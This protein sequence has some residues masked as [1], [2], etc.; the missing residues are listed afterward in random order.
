M[1]LVTHL[2]KPVNLSAKISDHEVSLKYAWFY[3]APIMPP[4]LPDQLYAHPYLEMPVA[5][6][7][8]IP[9]Y[10]ST[11]LTNDEIPSI[12]SLLPTFHSLMASQ[13]L[14]QINEQ[15]NVF[16][17]NQGNADSN[18]AKKIR[19]EEKWTHVEEV[20]LQS[21]EGVT[22]RRKRKKYFVLPFR[23]DL[24]EKRHSLFSRQPLKRL[25]L[26]APPLKWTGDADVSIYSVISSV[27]EPGQEM[28][29]STNWDR[30]L[31]NSCPFS[32]SPRVRKLKQNMSRHL[33]WSEKQTN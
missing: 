30:L 16:S 3:S 20:S 8:E 7:T 19:T 14:R 2:H 12:Y 32:L 13:A 21:V 23:V 11:E 31:E 4:P 29:S 22:R 24:R 15:A 10:T 5:Q 17:K 6:R 18:L 25:R 26:E 33:G 27:E 9:Q 1:L 28:H